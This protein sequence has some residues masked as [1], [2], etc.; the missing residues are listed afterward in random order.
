MTITT[1]RC[2]HR[3]AACSPAGATDG[4]TSLAPYIYP[5]REPLGLFIPRL[6]LS[7]RHR[8]VD[9]E[10]ILAGEPHGPVVYFA[11]V[12]RNVKI[13]TTGNLRARMRNLYLSLDDVLAVVPGSKEIEDLYHQ[14]FS[15]AR[16]EDRPELFRPNLRLRLFLARCQCSCPEAGAAFG[17]AFAVALSFTPYLLGVTLGALVLTA[18]MLVLFARPGWRW[19]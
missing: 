4:D 12:G 1:D 19:R 17:A 8:Y 10:K 16:F 5:P 3:V 14:R 6:T 13:G 9:V 15:S 11:R 18:I 2:R 7:R